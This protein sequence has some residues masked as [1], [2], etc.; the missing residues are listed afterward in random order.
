MNTPE[1]KQSVT[2]S[3][4]AVAQTGRLRLFQGRNTDQQPSPQQ[5][6]PQ[7]PSPQQPS[8]QQ[9]SPQQ[10]NKRRHGPAAFACFKTVS[11]CFKAETRTSSLRLSSLR[12]SSLRLQTGKGTAYYWQPPRPPAPRFGAISPRSMRGDI[13]RAPHDPPP[14]PPPPHTR[15][16]RVRILIKSLGSVY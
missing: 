5:P 11:A 2:S 15:S 8:P 10:A 6:S 13:S 16:S 3:E 4:Q 14:P 1:L 9:T 12:L 7:Q